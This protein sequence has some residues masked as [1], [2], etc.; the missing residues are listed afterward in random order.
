MKKIFFLIILILFLVSCG[1]VL[2]NQDIPRTG[3]LIN[4]PTVSLVK[5]YNLITKST[6]VDGKVDNLV[7]NIYAKHYGTWKLLSATDFSSNST[8]FKNSITVPFISSGNQTPQTIIIPLNTDIRI[9]VEGTN[10]SGILYY[11][12]YETSYI[13]TSNST[14]HTI[15]AYEIN[16]RLSF[17]ISNLFHTSNAIF[18]IEVDYA[19]SNVDYDGI[20]QGDSWLIA[21]PSSSGRLYQNVPYAT[22][23]LISKSVT[24]VVDAKHNTLTI[25]DS[26]LGNITPSDAN[27]HSA[28]HPVY[29]SELLGQGCNN[30]D[31]KVYYTVTSIDNQDNVG[32]TGDIRSKT[33]ISATNP[34]VGTPTASANIPASF[35]N[36]WLQAGYNFVITFT[37]DIQ[38]GSATSV[39][40]TLEPNTLIEGT[41][42]IH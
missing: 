8:G 21:N 4:L 2:K 32:T 18:T 5:S 10:G 23:S 6:G 31:F 13:S 40:G 20:L 19:S 11:G 24:T 28:Q 36:N 29:I 25:T 39:I 41:I 3:F 22:P 14:P 38:S 26:V 15:N 17:D 12:A 30:G 1:D 42:T 27:Y 37:A 33:L 7:Y 35:L 9:S 34:T 16:S